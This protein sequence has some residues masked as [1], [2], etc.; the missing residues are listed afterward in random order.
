MRRRPG[1]LLPL[2]VGILDAV[3]EAARTGD[4]WIHGYAIA[5]CISDARRAKRLTSQGTLYNALARLSEAGHL[6][7]R[8]EDPELAL[9]AGRPRRRLYRVTGLGRRALATALDAGRP[10]TTRPGLVPS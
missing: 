8:W 1:S 5:R 3:V 9:E 10:A 2:E 6:E 7:H 4:E